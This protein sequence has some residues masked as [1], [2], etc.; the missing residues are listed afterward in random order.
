MSLIVTDTPSWLEVS[1]CLTNSPFWLI[2]E[3]E[4]KPGKVRETDTI[5]QHPKVGDEEAVVVSNVVADLGEAE[6]E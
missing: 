3:V 1:W 4:A 5:P 2:P 6:S